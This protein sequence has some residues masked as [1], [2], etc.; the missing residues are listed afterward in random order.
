MTQDSQEEFR[1]Q[2]VERY[3]KRP[4]DP[5]LPPEMELVDT[6]RGWETRFRDVGIVVEIDGETYVGDSIAPTDGYVKLAKG[7]PGGDT[8]KSTDLDV[9]VKADMR[10]NIVATGGD[11]DAE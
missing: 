11:Y 6:E 5:D 10:S 1:E 8:V 3:P 4:D 2:T 9:R 7:E